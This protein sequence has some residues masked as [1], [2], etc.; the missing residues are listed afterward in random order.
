MDHDTYSAHDAIGRVYFDL[1]P[2]LSRGQTRCLNG[3]FP[4]YDTMHGIR[5]EISLAIRVDVFLDASR[6]YQSSLGVRFFHSSSV[7]DGYTIDFLIGFI[8]ELVM[9]DDPEHQWIEK[10]RTSRASNEARQRLFSR[11]SGELQRKLGLKVLNLGGN[12]VIGYQ[13]HYDLEGETG[14]VVRGIGTAVRLRKLHLIRSPPNSP[15]SNRSKSLH[16]LPDSLTDSTVN[17]AESS[18]ISE[19]ERNSRAAQTGGGFPGKVHKPLELGEFPFLTISQLPA[20]M[21]RNFASVVAAQSVKLM[22]KNTPAD[23]QFRDAWWLELRTEV[24][25]HMSSVGCNAV[26]GYHEECA[27]YEDVCILSNYGTAVVLDL[28]F[29]SSAASGGSSQN[30]LADTGSTSNAGTTTTAEGGELSE[31][32][33]ADDPSIPMNSSRP[34]D[35]NSRESADGTA[36]SS[37]YTNEINRRKTYFGR[38]HSKSRSSNTD[39][40]ICHL[41][42]QPESKPSRD[43]YPSASSS[44]CAV[45]KAASVPDLL[46]S[47]ADF[48]PELITSGKPSLIQACICRS[49]KESKGEA[50]ANEL[51]ELLSFVEYELHYRLLQKLRLRGMNGLFGLKFHI[52]ISDSLIAAIAT[53]TGVFITALPT[54]P[55]PKVSREN[56]LNAST[57]ERMSLTLLQKQLDDY[58]HRNHQLFGISIPPF[59]ETESRADLEK[60]SNVGK[61][62]YR[63]PESMSIN[64]I[65]PITSFTPPKGLNE[66]DPFTKEQTEMKLMTKSHG[67]VFLETREPEPE[68]LAAL[69]KDP[70]QP[71]GFLVLTTESFPSTNCENVPRPAI[72]SQTTGTDHRR[73]ASTGLGRSSGT[74]SDWTPFH[75]FVRVHVTELST[76]DSFFETSSSPPDG[77]ENLVSC[78]PRGESFSGTPLD[79][80]PL[81]LVRGSLP[82]SNLNMSS[83]KTDVSFEAGKTWTSSNFAVRLPVNRCPRG[84]LSKVLTDF[85]QLTLFRFRHLVPCAMNAVNFRLTVTDDDQVQVITTGMILVPQQCSLGSK[86]SQSSE[87]FQLIPGPPSNSTKS[88]PVEVEPSASAS[89]SV[90]GEDGDDFNGESAFKKRPLGECLDEDYRCQRQESTTRGR[91]SQSPELEQFLDGCLITPLSTVPGKYVEKFLGNLDFFFIRETTDLREVGGMCGFLHT[92]LSEVQ[93]VVAAHTASLGGNA[94][95]SYQFSEV[96]ILRPASRNQA[97]CLLNICGDM[98]RI[99]PARPARLS[100]K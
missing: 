22:D 29:A 66:V 35:V 49:K 32:R 26:I 16:G 98:A 63:T 96:V 58:V 56:M 23:I 79:L 46:L 78:H 10:I 12:S 7:P 91:T 54:P 99:A 27:I 44:R 77:N 25:H 90:P 38:R 80:S 37:S 48:P 36:N 68:E 76:S 82:D 85:N 84:R 72:S 17:L 5:G 67:T 52:S 64:E 88:G 11:L 8:Q 13:L 19:H 6:Y 39:C 40:S 86:F 3:W 95:L 92:S 2:L 18:I 93:A 45:C 73:S 97:Q 89:G 42:W 83:S 59:R 87:A 55:P 21:I 94:L 71:S 75:S 69:I 24:M 74:D 51:S 47:S 34:I 4:I 100:P 70:V 43:S 30:K 15:S 62:G 57:E 20:G 81:S 28:R 14:V 50:A 41:P 53:G 65:N 31:A 1:N 33:A 9:N 61:V 60:V